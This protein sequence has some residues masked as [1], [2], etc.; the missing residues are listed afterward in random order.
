MTL[1]EQIKMYEVRKLDDE[2]LKLK[3]AAY[4]AEKEGLIS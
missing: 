1:N 3:F 2:N 4:Q